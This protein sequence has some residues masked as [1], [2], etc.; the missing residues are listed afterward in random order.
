MLKS[1]G[2]TDNVKSVDITSACAESADNMDILKYHRNIG[3]VD[4]ILK[5]VDDNDETDNDNNLVS[6]NDKSRTLRSK[7][8]TVVNNSLGI[9]LIYGT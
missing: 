4:M 8:C 7:E 5:A 3:I 1:V 9:N 6:S 2:N